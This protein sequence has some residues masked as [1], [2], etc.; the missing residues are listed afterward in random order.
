MAYPE[1]NSLLLRRY[2]VTQKGEQH[3]KFGKDLND[4]IEDKGDT[5]AQKEGFPMKI[6]VSNHQ[7]P[8]PKIALKWVQDRNQSRLTPIL[9]I[10][11]S[12]DK[13]D[14]PLVPT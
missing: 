10:E 3:I 7:P 1:T 6:Q 11:M 9:A 12:I 5:M 4:S 8:D 14:L 2:K 13:K